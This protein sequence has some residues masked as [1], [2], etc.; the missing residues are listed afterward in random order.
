MSD[1]GNPAAR[2]V[3]IVRTSVVGIV[4]NLVL[5]AF[6]AAV[7]I[8][9]GSIAVILDAVNNLSDALS[10][11]IT[12][13]GTKLA[14]RRPDK[15]HPYGYGRIEYLTGV[16]ISVIVLLAGVTSIRE[17]V[18]KIISPTVAEYNTVSLV[19]IGAAIV[20]KLVMGQYVKRMGKEVNSS[21]LIASG[22]DALFDAILSLGTLVAAVLSLAFHW[23]LEGVIGTV[24]SLFIIKSGLE[25]LTETLNGIIGERADKELT[26]KLKSTINAYPQVGGTYDVILHHYGPSQIIGSA[27]VELPD[28]M[29]AREIHRLTRQITAEVYAAFGIVLTIG[30]YA[31]NDYDP[32]I[33]AIKADVERIAGSYNEILQTHGFYAEDDQITFDLIVDFKADAPQIREMM[34]KELTGIYPQYHFTVILDSD[35]SD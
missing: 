6:K 13:I 21:A 23:S 15:K 31:S 12:I 16:V 32:A 17:S 9:T 11:V 28:Q 30:I 5:V 29:T 3:K 25:M 19:I 10:S 4:G 18:G 35:Y 7:G 22:S 33:A 34:I 24:I 14:G 2:E 1:R 20:A 27:H 26:D 8:V